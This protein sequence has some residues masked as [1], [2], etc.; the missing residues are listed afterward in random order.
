[1]DLSPR[2]AKIAQPRKERSHTPKAWRQPARFSEMHRITGGIWT[3]TPWLHSLT[4]HLGE[5]EVRRRLW[6]FSPGVLALALT[7]VPHRE[8]IRFW[9]MLL[10]VICGIFLPAWAAL[11]HQRACQR[12]T[13]ENLA[14]SIL[15][16]VIPVSI[17]AL[18]FRSHVEI[19]LTVTAMI[20]FGDGSATLL[21]L[22]AGR[23]KLPWNSRKSWAGLCAFLA[24]G[25]LM[26]STVY[27]LAAHG[28]VT[29]PEAVLYLMP[30]VALCSVVE[31]LP[32]KLNDNLT[33]GF[34]ASVLLVLMQF[35]M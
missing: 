16:Y 20:A 7:I 1:M 14:P 35:W 28:S 15:G 6:H 13:G 9:V 23:S 31:T 22:L 27:W 30:V 18:L 26:T 10:I 12:R 3:S 24:V 33:V 2:S 8:T 17:L 29:F 19:P 4:Q 25:T 21:G 5:Q 32:L 34:A 11:R